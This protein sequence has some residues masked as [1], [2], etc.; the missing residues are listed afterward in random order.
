MAEQ[1]KTRVPT[2]APTKTTQA[3][4][5]S[6]LDKLGAS[7][8]SL[9]ALQTGVQKSL[10][11]SRALGDLFVE[12]INPAD[13]DM[14]TS[15][16]YSRTVRKVENEKWL[17]TI[18]TGLSD[19][20]TNPSH[21]FSSMDSASFDRYLQ[22]AAQGRTA[23]FDGDEFSE[24]HRNDFVGMLSENLPKLRA[25]HAKIRK[26]RNQE[27][28][29]ESTTD[30]ITGYL[31]TPGRTP[32]QV[33]EYL[34]KLPGAGQI[35]KGTLVNI[36]ASASQSVASQGSNS[37]IDYI[38]ANLL[39]SHPELQSSLN[40]AKN[41][42][43]RKV[44]EQEATR[45]L[46]VA[47]SLESQADNGI[48][49]NT[50]YMSAWNDPAVRRA[51][52]M[53]WFLRLRRTNNRQRNTQDNVQDLVNK[54]KNKQEILSA[55]A[56]DVNKAHDIV[57]D[58]LLATSPDTVSALTEYAKLGAA[59]G[60]LSPK[61]K[62]TIQRA[63]T[64]TEGIK[65]GSAA[66]STWFAG[67]LLAE[68]YRQAGNLGLLGLD[69][70]T[71]LG[72]KYAY[73]TFNLANTRTT[74]SP[75]PQEEAAAAA[76]NLYSTFMTKSD[77]GTLPDILQ[78]R[79]KFD[80][81]VDSIL[82]DRATSGWLWWKN[83]DAVSQEL[84]Q[85]LKDAT[86]TLAVTT[87]YDKLDDLVDAAWSTIER[88]VGEFAGTQFRQPEVPLHNIMQVP[89]AKLPE[90]ADSMLLSDPVQ[91]AFPDVDPEDLKV[92]VVGSGDDAAIFINSPDGSVAPVRM[93]ASEVADAYHKDTVTK[94]A[95]ADMDAETK[96]DAKRRH[97]KVK[98]NARAARFAASISSFGSRVDVVSDEFK[99]LYFSSSKDTQYLMATAWENWERATGRRK[100]V[101]S[102][103][104][105]GVYESAQNEQFTG[106][107][108][109]LAAKVVNANDVL[110]Q[111]LVGG[112]IT[113][114]VGSTLDEAAPDEL[115]I[116][117][118]QAFA[119][120]IQN[121]PEVGVVP[122]LMQAGATKTLLVL[123]SLENMD[124]DEVEIPEEVTTAVAK[125]H[126]V[127]SAFS[128]LDVNPFVHSISIAMKNEGGFTPND[129]GNWEF[130]GINKGAHPDWS[131]W[132]IVEKIWD[133]DTLYPDEASK[134]S[135]I[136]ELMEDPVMRTNVS[137]F[138][139]DN[140]YNYIGANNISDPTVRI[141]A[142]DSSLRTSQYMGAKLMRRAID[143]MQAPQV[144]GERG[145]ESTSPI[146][147][148][149]ARTIDNNID[150]FRTAFTQVLTDFYESLEG[151]RGGRI[152]AKTVK[153]WLDRNEWVLQ[154][155]TKNN[156]KSIL[157]K[158]NS[159]LEIL[160][161]GNDTGD[162][163]AGE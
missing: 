85:A 14:Q 102:R 74:D 33:E 128:D 144:A 61:F 89:E 87:N 86:F 62:G 42:Y 115:K 101:A 118:A 91:L 31:S 135:A 40:T 69:D 55:S 34:S 78:D 28:L 114:L 104:L 38:E 131:G 112:E 92:E 50:A 45:I 134:T 133:N 63:V 140:F 119:K 57:Y 120:K 7:I 127:A 67:M 2:L 151:G 64:A 72:L 26:A 123:N 11:S 129:L 53:E 158:Y 36:L 157:N 13:E 106:M 126:P 90:V 136:N 79:R 15:S 100:S 143:K 76:Y 148:A 99:D 18:N 159:F 58:D 161:A 6:V 154:N 17:E 96:M 88:S 37:G 139:H 43:Y 24:W 70:K 77:R 152:T 130:M 162:S 137:K 160:N 149:E 1:F 46:G 39:G 142:F 83:T 109:D 5:T 93:L 147:R 44:D 59:S 47:T 98:E 49:D 8:S 146:T 65:E 29:I 20:L 48:L 163:G 150:A 153:S 81:K 110:T 56:Q 66:P 103:R 121:M 21:E 32:E 23:A 105:A 84:K 71:A 73:D 124:L 25:N 95:L 108:Q 116:A 117:E 156:V 54:I 35:P 4:N 19:A 10:D 41:A 30:A 60:Q 52:S 94:K 111:T 16:A 75:M 122:Y 107:I 9:G 125:T 113:E 80:K 12:K 22:E 68:E 138:Y 141:L 155:A 145:E 82:K 27:K 51:K 97:A 132:K 3:R